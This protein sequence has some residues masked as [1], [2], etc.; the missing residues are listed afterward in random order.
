MRQTADRLL[1]VQVSFCMS[2]QPEEAVAQ[3]GDSCRFVRNGKDVPARRPAETRPPRELRDSRDLDAPGHNQQA[4]HPQVELA[5]PRRGHTQVLHT[6]CPSP[7]IR[8]DGAVPEHLST[9]SS[10]MA[11]PDVR[12]VRGLRSRCSALAFRSTAARSCRTFVRLQGRHDRHLDSGPDVSE[13]R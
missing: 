9:V 1:D 11:H 12:Q 8:E 7:A 10:L 13:V 5:E 6:W 3:T 2:R 4:P